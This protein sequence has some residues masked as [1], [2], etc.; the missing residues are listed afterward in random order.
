MEG[1]APNVSF[2]LGIAVGVIGLLLWRKRPA[3]TD[4]SKLL[5]GVL[6]VMQDIMGSPMPDEEKEFIIRQQQAKL[7]AR[8]RD[9]INVK[10]GLEKEDIPLVHLEELLARAIRKVEEEEEAKLDLD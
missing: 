2:L 10:W 4:N 6:T 1:V 9:R 8:L 7:R 3:A 5:N